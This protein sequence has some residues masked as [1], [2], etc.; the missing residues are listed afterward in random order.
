MIT[1]YLDF[2]ARS[3]GLSDAVERLM[4][5]PA[6]LLQRAARAF[7]RHR[8]AALDRD[9]L[10]ALD[11]RLLADLGLERSL[12]DPARICRRSG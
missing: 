5:A 2:S 1:R 6:R 3:F 11:R 4:T 10:A 8:E 7:D 9:V 12:I